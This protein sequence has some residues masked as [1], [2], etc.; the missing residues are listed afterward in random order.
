MLLAVLPFIQ[1][2]CGKSGT[3]A[4]NGTDKFGTNKLETVFVEGNAKQKEVIQKA[5]AAIKAQ[6]YGTAYDALQGL[7]Q[8]TSLSA[9]Q[10]QAIKDSMLVLGNY[11]RRAP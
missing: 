10:T 7:Y 6:D 5:E 4:Q 9:E 3:S 11:P 1:G 8:D 2:G